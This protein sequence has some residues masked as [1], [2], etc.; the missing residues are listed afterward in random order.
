M[1]VENKN[2]ATAP[3]A[4]AAPAGTPAAAAAPAANATAENAPK[5]TPPADK[6]APAAAAAAPAADDKAAPDAATAKAAADK[7]AADKAKADVEK[8]PVVPEKYEFKRGEDSLVT[9]DRLEELQA[10]C[11]AEGLTM[12]DA[13]KRLDAIERDRKAE[14]NAYRERSSKWKD[15]VKNHKV[16]GGANAAKSAEAAKRLVD[17]HGSPEF[18]KLVGAIEAGGTGLGDHPEF[19]FFCAS[20][21]MEGLDDK[22]PKGGEG[23]GDLRHADV[24]Y[25]GKGKK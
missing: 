23:G 4:E 19:V 5:E 20:I 13:Q 15:E 17:A 11:K 2:P 1:T 12:E 9:D 18:K 7:E 22:M 10:E 16:W 3:A 14:R 8:K 21:G 25:G 24:M 6:A